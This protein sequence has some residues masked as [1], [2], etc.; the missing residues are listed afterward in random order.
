M[1][2]EARSAAE[3]AQGVS[4]KTARQGKI[5][6]LIRRTTVRSQGELVDKLAEAGVS[7]T[8][9]TLSRDLVEL[10]AVKVRT[11][12]GSVYAVP[13]EGGDRSLQQGLGPELLDAKLQRLLDE[14]LVSVVSSGNFVLL[15][16]PPGA[17]QYLASA[18]DHSSIPHIMG[19]I[20]GDDTVLVIAINAEGG[21]KV[22]DTLLELT[23]GRG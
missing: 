8:Q 2:A 22:A 3:S 9:A 1:T 19:T 4:T 14:L 20:A 5:V 15:R 12:D 7:V 18:I 17:A 6:D 11:A 23:R 13:G 16:T 10:G 21:A